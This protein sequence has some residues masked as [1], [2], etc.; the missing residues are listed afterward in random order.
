MVSIRRLNPFAGLPNPR[1]VWAWGMY[2]LANQSFTLLINT[3][4][5]SVYF[6]EVVAGGG[7]RGDR[8]W[9]IV[10]SVSMFLVVLASPV[11]GA[12][13]DAK[14]W[15]KEMLMASGIGCVIFTCGLGL[16]GPGTVALA[17]A[18]YI[19][20]NFLYQIG[21]NTL[22]SFL[23]DIASQ[24]TIGKISALGWMMGYV[25]ALCLLLIVSVVM[26]IFGLG[27]SAQWR[28]LFVFA[29][30]W[31]LLG[32]IPP[33]LFLHERKRTMTLRHSTILAEAISRIAD[34]F[35]HAR[36]YRQLMLFLLAFFIYAFGMQTVIAFAAILAKDFGFQQTQLV[37][38]VLQITVTAG[39]AAAA[40]SRF[41][42]RIGAKAT[43]MIY[44]GVWIVSTSSL[45]L[46]SGINGLPH[47]LLWVVGNGI[48]FG[49]GGTG[50]ASRAMVGR[51]TPSHKS[52][53]FFGLWGV[54]YKLAAAIGVLSFGLVKAGLGNT[55]ALIL[56]T[57]F[58]VVGMLLMIPVDELAGVR[59]AKRAE[60]EAG[61]DRRTG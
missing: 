38:F 55:M 6:K 23:P 5:F 39:I 24:R 43:I 3:L 52:A 59:S 15:R 1:E 21:E 18:L 45:A 32:M 4:L 12:L 56:L 50:T 20:A 22:A 28:P 42:D 35:H 30:I 31:F 47:W 37:L 29:G 17:F 33:M 14:N 41:Q 51:F 34:T 60:R 25:G 9:S 58:F 8:L 16:T 27:S 49:L 2:D 53:E 57:S 26:K 44:L 13:A 10:F 46:I 36:H 40:T 19:P 54:S 7:Q 61:L 48:G 11:L